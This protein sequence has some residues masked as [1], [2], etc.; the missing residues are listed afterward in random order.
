LSVKPMKVQAKLFWTYLLL[1]FLGLSI[2][3]VLIFSSERKR[4]LTQLEQ[5][6]GYQT[7][8]LSNIFSPLLVDSLDIGKIDSLTDEL[9]QK[10][11]S[12]ITIINESGKVVGDSYESG[13]NLLGMENH[14]DRPEVASAL[15]GK[16]G[17]SI[18]YSHTIK[19]DM[20]Y[21]A[22]AIQ[23][24]KKTIGV[25]RLALPLNELQH[26]NSMILKLVLLGLFLAFIFS[27]VLSFGFSNQVTKPLRKM[28]E[29]GKKMSEG[30]FTRRI[31][32]KT[33]DEI[34]ELGKTLNQMSVELSEKIAEITEDRSQLQSILSS[35]IEGIL[36]VDQR[37]KVLLANDALSR[38]FELNASFYGKPHY[39]V[40]RD[41]ELNE[42]I[43]EVLSSEQEKRN[44]ISFIHPREGDFLIQSALVK[45]P[46][47]GGIF[48]VFSFHD[49]TE[50][51]RLERVRKDFVANVSHELRTPLTSIKGFVEALQD[52]AIN[53]PN[54]SA[55]FLSI[56]SQHTDRMNKIISDL[57]QLSQIESKE[58][59]LKIE[60][61]S[62]KELV[63]EVVYTLKR[64]ADEKLQNLEVHLHSE[65]AK[66]L[67]DKYKINQA[68][69]N[70]VDNAVKYTPEKGSIKIESRDKGE[71]VEIAVIDNGIGIPQNDLPRIFERFYTVDKSRSRE[72]GGT[73]LGL[74]IVKHIIEA[75]GGTVNVRSQLGK[76]SEFIFTLKKT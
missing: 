45:H 42:F 68:L 21:V 75:H 70:L 65:D 60:P 2:A 47:E 32:I 11:D 33:K 23:V 7:Q 64:S 3:G 63:E 57:L 41:P 26:Q 36:A 74:S 39:E 38:M 59:G 44:E 40:I 16:V 58:F 51:K 17:K 13:E 24:Q 22:S 34:G 43:Q 49:I 14:K 4:L 48:A 54:Q 1:S 72:L 76:G 12:R 62:V 28:V 31:K 30:D 27:L 35:M 29:V 5:N 37:G 50:L 56:I 10:I 20:L 9:G 8:L 18:R 15:Q 67:G 6:M 73:G 53:D 71:V 69:T 19:A 46:R 66:V 52:G 61:F 25:A 55:K